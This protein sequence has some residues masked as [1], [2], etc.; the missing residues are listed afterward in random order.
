MTGQMV[1]LVLSLGLDTLA[2]STT[3][4]MLGPAAKWRIALALGGAEAI[5]PLVG[6]GIGR[7]AG[8]LAGPGAAV[9]GGLALVGVGLWI[10]FSDEDGREERLVRQEPRG[11]ALALMALGVSVDELAAG[12]GFGLGGRQIV[13]T[14]LVIGAQGMVLAWAGATFGTRIRPWLGEWT[15]RLA[16]GVLG[17]LG[18]W[19]LVDWVVK[20][21]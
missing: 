9:A 5:M 14:S 3:L 12:L 6:M 18:V 7:V 17:L 20:P 16:G 2:V 13:L 1:A 10:L 19:M 8:R 4:G 21:G 11:V 15:E